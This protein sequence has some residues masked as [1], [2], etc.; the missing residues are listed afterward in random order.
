MIDSKFL[1]ALAAVVEEGGFDKAASRLHITQSAVSQRIRSLEEHMGR[2]LV[3]RITPPEATE[4]GRELIR[5]LRKVRLLEQELDMAMESRSSQGFVPL[6]V[7]VNADSL[8]TWFLD[9]VEDFIRQER[10]LLDICVDDENRTHELLRR[11]EVVGCLGARSA[12]LKGCRSDYCGTMEYLCVCTPEF[13]ELWFPRGITLE[14]AQQAPAALF[15]RKDE[16]H[17][18]MLALAFPGVSVSHPVCYVPSSESFADMVRR[19]LAYGV[20]PEPQAREDLDTGRLVELLPEARVP[21]PLYWQ[22]W[23]VDTPLLAGLR[24]ALVEYY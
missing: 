11:G 19:G 10:V 5:H 7:A 23:N 18:R 9:A 21:V 22:S 20:V 17:V 4:A 12:P 13:R 16:N 6:P 2:V 1:E 14:C 3:A 8:A 15:N 24:T